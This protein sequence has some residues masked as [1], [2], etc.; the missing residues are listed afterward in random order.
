MWNRRKHRARRGVRTVSGALHPHFSIN[1]HC[2]LQR[3]AQCVTVEESSHPK[4]LQKVV[5]ED[6]SCTKMHFAPC[7][8][9]FYLT[10]SLNSF[11]FDPV[12]VG[13]RQSDG[14]IT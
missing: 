9:A 4:Q 1:P 11:C 3:K 13:M 8:L 5:H 14:S 12:Q 7:L 10:F 2:L 6:Q